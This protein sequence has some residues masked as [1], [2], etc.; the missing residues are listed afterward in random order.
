MRAA[1]MTS[2]LFWAGP[3]AK[4]HEFVQLDELVRT[5]KSTFGRAKS[6]LV[7]ITNA[8]SLGKEFDTIAVKDGIVVTMDL[9]NWSGEVVL[10]VP[11]STDGDVERDKS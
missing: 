1:P 6:E 5:L 9:K 4:T 11:E 7:L 3:P 10:E 8:R 2:R